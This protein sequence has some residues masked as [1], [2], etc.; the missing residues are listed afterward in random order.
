MF[1][2]DEILIARG[3]YSTLSRE[4]RVQLERVRKTMDHLQ[5]LTVNVVRT[6]TTDEPQYKV[7]DMRRCL[8]SLED[9]AGKIIA[10]SDEMA[11]LKP[12]AWDDEVQ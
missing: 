12:L 11:E 8:D 6:M 3:K 9:A 7:A 1:P 5:Q 2:A 4:R 10:L